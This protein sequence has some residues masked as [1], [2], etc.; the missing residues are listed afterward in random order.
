MGVEWNRK[1]GNDIYLVAPLC[2]NRVQKRHSRRN[3]QRMILCGILPIFP[4][5]VRSR[6]DSTS[7]KESR[8]VRRVR[9]RVATVL[10]VSISSSSMDRSGGVM[11]HELCVPSQ[12]SSGRRSSVDR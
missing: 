4:M 12:T 1:V 11:D 2:G 9:A 3:E 7:K 6:I 10:D 8:A 5:C